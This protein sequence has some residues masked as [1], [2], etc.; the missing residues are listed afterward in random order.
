VSSVVVG[1][2]VLGAAPACGGGGRKSATEAAAPVTVRIKVFAFTPNPVTVN[3]GTTVTW[4]N[5]DDITHTVTSG[6][7]DYAPGDTGRVVA[8][9]KDAMFDQS[10][11]GAGKRYSFRFAK[12]GTF[13]Y[14][15]DRHPGMEADVKVS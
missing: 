6:T 12:E 1:A 9:H 11:D 5:D 13:H 2:L 15:C 10:L 14:F 3:R 8:T 7:R 4:V